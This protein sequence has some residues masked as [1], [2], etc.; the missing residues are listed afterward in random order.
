MAHR[1]AEREL[2]LG[3][4]GAFRVY[5]EGGFDWTAGRVRPRSRAEVIASAEVA[6]VRES[7]SLDHVLEAADHGRRGRQVFR[8][9]ADR[10]AEP[11]WDRFDESSW[12]GVVVLDEVVPRR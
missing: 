1:H 3:D 10:E 2:G 11:G 4:W 6:P 9:L 5:I 12:T 7:R 8:A